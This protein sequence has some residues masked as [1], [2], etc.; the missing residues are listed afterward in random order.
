MGKSRSSEENKSNVIGETKVKFYDKDLYEKESFI[1]ITLTI[2]I[3][4]FLGFL[5]GCIVLYE[6]P[7]LTNNFIN[8]NIIKFD[9]YEM[10]EE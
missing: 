2:L 4:F 10:S 7:K 1:K 3:L 8:N 5:T 6:Q 9:A